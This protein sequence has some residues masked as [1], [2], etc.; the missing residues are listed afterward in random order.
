MLRTRP[1]NVIEG[2]GN[3]GAPNMIVRNDPFDMSEVRWNAPVGEVRS[4]FHRSA[5][6]R[7]ARQKSPARTAADIR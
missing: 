4:F 1:A 2:D 7:M 5:V 3:K 6:T